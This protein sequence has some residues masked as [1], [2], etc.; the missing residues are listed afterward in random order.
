MEIVG[1]TTVQKYIS[2]QILTHLLQNCNVTTWSLRDS[3]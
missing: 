1:F 3:L 2:K